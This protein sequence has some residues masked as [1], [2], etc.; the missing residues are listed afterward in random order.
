MINI[1]PVIYIK[2]RDIK[3]IQGHQ[4][5]DRPRLSEVYTLL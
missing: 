2:Q 5:S 3:I 1:N 4:A